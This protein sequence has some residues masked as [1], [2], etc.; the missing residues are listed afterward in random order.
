MHR[1]LTYRK[2]NQPPYNQPPQEPINLASLHR[3]VDS[4]IMSV[5]L[6]F[7]ANPLNTAVQQ[8]LKALLDLQNILQQQRL[9]DAQLKQIRDQ[10]SQLSAS[11]AKP[12]PPPPA[13]AALPA[14]IPNPAVSTPPIG[15][16]PAQ[17]PQPNLQALLNPNTLAELIKA[18]AQKPT[19]TQQ[20]QPYTQPAVPPPSLAAAVQ[21]PTSLA[22]SPLIASLRARGLLP[23]AT[24][25]PTTTP[26]NL[27]FI[28]PGQP[29]Y[30]PVPANT[31][32]QGVK[33][34]VPMTSAS[35]RM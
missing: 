19:P 5:R 17:A 10:V 35:I 18:T 2:P 30:T 29:A 1:L 13:P 3:D 12:T 11:S 32:S 28:I 6:E 23:P 16:V 21:P 7:T 34:K 15:T 8:K 31:N 24:G 33:I 20:T 4:L 25:T 26:P 27:P 9:P 22:E 14:H